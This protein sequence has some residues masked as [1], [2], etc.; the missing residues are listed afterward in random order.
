MMLGS[1]RARSVAVYVSVA[2]GFA[3]DLTTNPTQPPVMT[4]GVP[5]TIVVA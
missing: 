1:E 3:V 4:C 2:G 5:L